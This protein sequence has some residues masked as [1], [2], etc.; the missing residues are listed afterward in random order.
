MTK[1][2]MKIVLC[3]TLLIVLM[4]LFPPWVAIERTTHPQRRFSGYHFITYSGE[5]YALELEKASMALMTDE[6]RKIYDELMNE[7]PSATAGKSTGYASKFDFSKTTE[8]R[9]NYEIYMTVLMIQWLC[10]LLLTGV[11]YMLSDKFGEV[12]FKLNLDSCLQANAA[13]EYL[14]FLKYT[15]VSIV[16]LPIIR[17]SFYWLNVYYFNW[18]TFNVTDNLFKYYSDSWGYIFVPYLLSLLIRS[19]KW[20]RSELKQ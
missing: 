7:K 16:A 8:S 18:A 6:E 17:F 2:Q 14:Y 19:I 10:V 5:G 3:G 4:G 11:A 9:Y 12:K 1:I 15:A 13:R 20:A